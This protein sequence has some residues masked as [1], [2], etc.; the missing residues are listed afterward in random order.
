VGIRTGCTR[1]G[2]L[3]G[4][5]FSAVRRLKFGSSVRVLLEG[6][7]EWKDSERSF[8]L[9]GSF[10]FR[11]ARRQGVQISLA[12]NKGEFVVEY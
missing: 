2:R 1:R 10:N 3:L 7:L 12:R 5:A 4:S 11:V 8:S 9:E 6:L